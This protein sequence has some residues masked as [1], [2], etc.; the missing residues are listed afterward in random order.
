MSR[1]HGGV[2][3][4]LLTVKTRREM[5]TERR[6]CTLPIKHNSGMGNKATQGSIPESYGMCGW[7]RVRTPA[8]AAEERSS[9]ALANLV[10]RV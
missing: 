10:K 8:G 5:K 7:S 6:N 2:P 1:R 4:S 3:Q 9:P